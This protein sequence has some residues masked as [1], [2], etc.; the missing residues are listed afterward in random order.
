MTKAMVSSKP[1][2]LRAM[3]K[4]YLLYLMCIPGIAFFLVFR[5]VPMWGI[6]VSFQDFNIFKGFMESEWV[7]FTHFI[8]FFSS[9]MFGTLMINTLLISFYNVIFAFPAPI[10]L[11][12]LLN[13]LRLQW[14][15]RSI[16]T[17]I[18]I[19][20]FI[21]WVIVGTMTFMLLSSHGPINSILGLLGITPIAFLTSPDTFRSMVVVQGI[22]KGAGFGT[23]IFL[24]AL[25]SV[26]M[27]Q[28]EAAI[29][30]GASRW[31]QCWH[32]TIPALKSVII[33]LLILQMG[34]V[35]ETS[36]DQMII[37]SNAGNR[38]VSDVIDVFVFREG[39][40]GGNFSF[41]TAIGVF[42]SVIGLILVVIADKTAKFVGESGLF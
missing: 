41:T 3:R 17:V 25:S 20:H 5:Y 21:S 26:D 39:V 22:W 35:F 10:V 28:Y 14:L 13:E 4:H 23:I 18:Y 32:I 1:K 40:V 29:V 37:M 15:K 7:G 19:P 31:R 8:R 12:L 6:L 38:A 9:P 27:E 33:L 24:A 34:N 42:Q 2:I 30:D 16:Q 36:F 11:A